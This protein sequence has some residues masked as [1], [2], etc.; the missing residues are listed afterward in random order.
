MEYYLSIKKSLDKNS[1]VKEHR[2]TKS[3]IV[4]IHIIRIC[5]ARNPKKVEETER[6]TTFKINKIE[7]KSTTTKKPRDNLKGKKLPL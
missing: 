4:L 3:A 7:S 6:I 5:G 1:S 2:H